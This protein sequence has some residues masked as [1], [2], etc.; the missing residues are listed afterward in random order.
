MEISWKYA[1]CHGGIIRPPCVFRTR[2]QRFIMGPYRTTNRGTLKPTSEGSSVLQQRYNI[3]TFL[4]GNNTSKNIIKPINKNNNSGI[5][6]LLN[7]Q[8]IKLSHTSSPCKHFEHSWTH[9][10]IP[11]ASYPSRPPQE[12]ITNV[13]WRQNPT[14][15]TTPWTPYILFP[16]GSNDHPFQMLLQSN[17]ISRIRE[18]TQG[19]PT[20]KVIWSTQTPQISILVQDMRDLIS[21]NSMIYHELLILSLEILCHEFQASYLDPSF[22][23][24]L[25]DHGWCYVSNRFSAMDDY[26]AQP[27]IESP[28]MAI[29]I[30][31]NGS[32]WV[33]LC[34]MI[35]NGR[36]YILHADDLNCPTT[37]REICFPPPRREP[38]AWPTQYGHAVPTIPI[39]HIPMN[40]VQE[41]SL[42]WPSWCQIA[43]YTRAPSSSTWTQ[44][45]PNSLEC[46]WV[47]SLLQGR[48]SFSP[49]P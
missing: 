9:Q 2:I 30:H 21:H 26:I 32:H 27:N 24:L 15:T 31:I 10:P 29:P 39:D 1:M 19:E 6:P 28:S 8:V 36:T 13:L 48:Y 44:T 41:Q 33:A 3:T 22:F 43:P 14:P 45:W 49:L 34:R 4:K 40:V 42:P 35:K 38:F 23:T 12:L 25:R 20:Q 11:P 47:T 5:N 37:E 7:R 16:P 17:N 46:G 18:Y